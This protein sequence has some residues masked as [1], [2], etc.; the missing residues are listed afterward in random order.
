MIDFLQLQYNSGTYDNPEWI[1]ISEWKNEKF[2]WM[3]LGKD[4]LNYRTVDSNKNVLTDKSFCPEHNKS[5][6][7]FT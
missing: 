5:K 1:V 4:C 7:R 6:E 2:A 3:S